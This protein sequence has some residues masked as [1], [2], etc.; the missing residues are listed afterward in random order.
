MYI[1][2][3]LNGNAFMNANRWRLSAAALS[4]ALLRGGVTGG[5]IDVLHVRENHV[6][7][8]RPQTNSLTASGGS[9]SFP[10]PAPLGYKGRVQFGFNSFRSFDS[11]KVFKLS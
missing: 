1:R 2:V 9:D 11:A 4:N 7:V 8:L 6:C 5:P 10:D 3:T